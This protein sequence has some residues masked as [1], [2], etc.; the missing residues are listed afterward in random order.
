MNLKK[1]EPTTHSSLEGFEK[2]LFKN[3]NLE[4][5]RP[6]KISYL[7]TNLLSKRADPMISSFFEKFITQQGRKKLKIT[8]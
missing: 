1:V 8:I 2:I 6:Q 5:E 7:E 3:L 4:K